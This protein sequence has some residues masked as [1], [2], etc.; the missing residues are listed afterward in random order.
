MGD[1]GKPQPAQI[2]TLQLD[3]GE[4]RPITDLARGAGAP[5]WSPDGTKIAFS[6]ATKDGDTTPPPPPKS[7]VRVITSAV[8]RANGGGWND[9][10]R[11]SHIWVTTVK[12]GEI[13][14]RC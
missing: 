9:V 11:P 14:N 3:G 1:D 6:T 5:V 7:D 8:Y 4:A 10:D 13:A 12:P 2:Y